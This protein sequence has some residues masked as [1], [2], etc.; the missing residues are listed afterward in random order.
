MAAAFF[1]GKSD[2][3]ASSLNKN[4]EAKLKVKGSKKHDFIGAVGLDTEL[5]GIKL[6]QKGLDT[7]KHILDFLEGVV[8][9]RKEQRVERDYLNTF[10]VWQPN[11]QIR[12][13]AKLK[14]GEKNLAFDDYFKF[15]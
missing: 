14:K 15:R 3:A 2:K 10:F 8:A 1:Y 6:L 7:E 13:P 5:T 4:L 12:I 9:D 11:L